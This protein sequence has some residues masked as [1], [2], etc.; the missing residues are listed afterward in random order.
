MILAVRSGEKK[1]T[2]PYLILRKYTVQFS[3]LVIYNFWSKIIFITVIKQPLDFERL[4]SPLMNLHKEEPYC[5]AQWEVPGLRPC[6][7]HPAGLGATMYRFGTAM[8]SQVWKS[9]QRSRLLLLSAHRVL[10]AAWLQV[11][12]FDIRDKMAGVKDGGMWEKSSWTPPRTWPFERAVVSGSLG[13]CC[14]VRHG[15]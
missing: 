6:W 4:F 15:Q 10:Y 5:A 8:E 1:T 3:Q 11:E 14:P 9:Y 12:A 2:Q 13:L 7:A